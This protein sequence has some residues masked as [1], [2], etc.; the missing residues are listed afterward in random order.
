LISDRLFSLPIAALPPGPDVNGKD[1]S[2]ERN[3]PRRNILRASDRTPVLTGSVGLA[4]GEEAEHYAQQRIPGLYDA[5]VQ[6]RALLAAQGFHP[7]YLPPLTPLWLFVLAEAE[8]TEGK[9][10]LGQLGSHIVAEFLLGSLRCDE[11]SVLFAALA[12]LQGWEPTATIAA[13]RRYS[14]PNLLANRQADA[15]VGG[16]LIRLFSH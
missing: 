3:L 4:T 13:I 15:K 5:T 8:T 12:N 10:R 16:R 11:G 7:N 2:T 9:Q 6:V 14:M 1:T